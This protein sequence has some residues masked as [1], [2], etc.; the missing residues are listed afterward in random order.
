MAEMR[1]AGRVGVL[2][3]EDMRVMRPMQWLSGRRGVVTGAMAMRRA[4]LID[5]G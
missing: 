4:R 2:M 5:A 3:E 1:D